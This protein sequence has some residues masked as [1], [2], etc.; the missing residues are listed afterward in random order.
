[1][2]KEYID[3]ICN[4]LDISVPDI[5]YDTST[6]LSETML[7]G[8]DISTYT[9][10]LKKCDESNPDYLFSIAHELRHLWQS[11]E[12]K[13]LYLSDYKPRTAFSDVAEYNLQLAEIDANAFGAL[14][15]IDA[16]GI[17]P[18]FQGMPEKVINTI[19]ERI[20][21]IAKTLA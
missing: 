4:I 17:E 2:I 12:D 15:M 13:E 6:F 20:K 10:Y 5:S 3:K 19:K 9:M 7:A 11:I 16:F 14:I 18:L 8:C 1:M 21:Y